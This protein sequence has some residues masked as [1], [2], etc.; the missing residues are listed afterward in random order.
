MGVLPS[1]FFTSG[2]WTNN[3]TTHTGQKV[4]L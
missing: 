3:K 4:L 2:F 1:A